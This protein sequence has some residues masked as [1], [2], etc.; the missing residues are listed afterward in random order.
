MVMQIPMFL[1]P[2]M[3]LT[4]SSLFP[5]YYLILQPGKIFTTSG[6]TPPHILAGIHPE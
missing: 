1:L 6:Y 5:Q 4:I 3:K 2:R